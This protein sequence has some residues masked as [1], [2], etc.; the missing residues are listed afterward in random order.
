MEADR[1]PR[2]DELAASLEA[3]AGEPDARLGAAIELGR[4]LTELGDALIG[5]FVA[6]ARAAGLS[7]TEIGRMFGTS[8]QA[9]Q[10][11]YG[12]ATT[13]EGEDWPGRWTPGVRRVLDSAGEEARAL[14][15]DY[16]G[17]EH[18]L[19][20]LAGT[21]GGVAAAVLRDL[22]V[23]PDRLL[24]TGCLSR[25]PVGRPPQ[26]CLPLMPRLKQALEHS[27]R[28]ADGLDV[29]LAD[30]EHLLAGI[31]A[32]PDSMAVEMLRRLSVT[33]A[34]VHAALAVRMGVA[35]RLLGDTRRRRRRLLSPSR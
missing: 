13:T 18:V 32:V 3:R 11:R 2:L 8:K 35:P 20:A 4:E 24:A 1:L 15:H 28:T 10:Q 34:E 7:W 22:G 6:D 30:T 23:A 17:T 19:L 9:V 26:P 16:V 21:E 33:P 5:R 14:D 31:A 12:P 27:R 25:G 29:R